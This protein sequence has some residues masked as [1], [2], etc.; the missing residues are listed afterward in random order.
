MTTISFDDIT[1]EVARDLVRTL[2]KH[3]A[4]LLKYLPDYIR[5][6]TGHKWAPATI[7][8]TLQ[9]HCRTADQYQGQWDL[10][11]RVDSG[12]WQLKPGLKIKD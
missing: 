8:C 2:T 9:R 10:F 3:K 6:V 5:K 11:E 12:C 7:R 4:P 1:S